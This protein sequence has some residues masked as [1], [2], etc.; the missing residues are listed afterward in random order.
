MSAS[1]TVAASD[2]GGLLFCGSASRRKNMATTNKSV[3]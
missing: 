1:L 3:N 2:A